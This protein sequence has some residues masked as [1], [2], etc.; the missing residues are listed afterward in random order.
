MKFNTFPREVGLPRQLVY[1]NND[2]L[3]FINRNN[4]KKNAIYTTVYSFKDINEKR[5]NYDSAI[6]DK[7]FFDFDDK[8][9]N[10]YFETKK[11]H[12]YCLN[13][14]IKHSLIMSGRG[15]HIYIY[16]QLMTYQYKKSAIRLAQLFFINKLNL[17]CD[18]QIVGDISR[19]TRIPNTHNGKG[20]RFCIPL[21]LLQFNKG[22]EFIKIL[23]KKQNFVKN[24]FIGKKKFDMKEFDIICDM[25]FIIDIPNIKSSSTVINISSLPFCIQCI[26]S[27]P[28]P[29]YKER[30][31]LILYLK[32][33]GY[34]KEEVYDIL[35][36]CLSTQKL[37][38]C[39]KEERQLHYLF[40]RHDLVFPCCK[41]IKNDNFCPKIC[42]F[43]GK[44]I[45]KEII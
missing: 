36:D 1:N 40:E 17:K 8:E 27:K 25:E 16:T 39:I 15:Y 33:K 19:L 34:T 3:S 6:I 22:D 5:P 14:N 10:A 42:E 13:K 38:H 41:K 28:N 32:E 11:L 31:L 37:Y 12:E 18:A 44:A 24:V 20:K 21:T 35:K 9:C 45:Y 30:Y 23:A 26:L 7:L 29:N 43:Y 2:Y 4:G